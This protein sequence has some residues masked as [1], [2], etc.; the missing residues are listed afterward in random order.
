MQNKKQP[1]LDFGKY[2]G[3]L[4]D[5]VPMQYVLFLAGFRLDGTQAEPL[6]TEASAWIEKN[7]PEIRSQARNFIRDKCWLCGSGLRAVGFDRTN[8]ACHKDWTT[9]KL[10]KK[11]WLEL[12]KCDEI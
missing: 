8:G 2:R 5:E 1:T 9:R 4:L 3:W 6:D 11:C 7:K 10:H 12:K